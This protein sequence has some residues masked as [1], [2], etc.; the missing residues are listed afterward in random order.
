MKKDK[1]IP[2]LPPSEV[3]I[4]LNPPDL[5]QPPK[6]AGG[7]SAI[8][9]TLRHT[10]HEMKTGDVIRS[11]LKVNKPDGF[12]CPGCAWPDPDDRRS[13]VEFCENGA[14]AIAE[15]ATRTRLELGYFKQNSI[16]AI[17]KLS[18]FELGHLGRL[19]HPM[20]KRQGSD[21]YESVSW[22]SAFDFIAQ[23]LNSL[24]SPNEATFY[25]SGRTSNEAAFL[26]Q[27]FV[28]M[29]GTNNLPDCSNM[30]HE[31]SGTALNE[32]IGIGKGTVTLED[33]NYADLILV[34]GQNPGTNHPRMMSALQAA[35]RR[36]CKIV[37]INPL[38]EVGLLAFKNPQEIQGIIGRG[39]PLASI[40]L[41]VRINGDAA[42][43][44]GIAKALIDLEESDPGTVLDQEFIKQKTSGFNTYI[45]HVKSISWELITNE[46]GIHLDQIRAVAKLIGNSKRMITCWAMGLTQHEN[47]VATIKE[48]VNVMLLGGHIG[49]KG[50]GVCP[51]RG[52]SN[53]QGDRTM[54]I[55]EK[56]PE[57]FLSRL[58]NEFS[59][60][61]PRADGLDT[62]DSIKAMHAG[63]V[64]V[65]IGLGGNFLS[66]TP[67]TFYTAEAL[68][69]C[70]LTVQISTKLNRSHLITGSQ[71]I[72]LPCL[73]R[74]EI[75]LQNSGPQFV[76]CE[77]SM[78][79]VQASQGHL[80]PA[81]DHL[82]SEVSIVVGLAQATLP[83]K[84]VNQIDKQNTAHEVGQRKSQ[85]DWLAFESN[86]NLIRDRIAKVI[87]G[88]ENYNSDILKPYGFYLPNGA[89]TQDF[90]TPSQKA[91]F[92][93]SNIKST[94]L[95]AGRYLLM[96]IRSHDQ[97]NTTIYGLNDR[98]RGIENGRRVV[99]MNSE[100][101]LDAGLNKGA[102]VDV[103]SHYLPNNLPHD[104]SHLEE[105]TR[106]AFKFTVVPYD[107]PRKC[108]A[109]YFPETNV[110]VPI[111]RVADK[112]NTP[113]YKSIEVS[114]RVS[115]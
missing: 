70:R 50:A 61:A 47:A 86:Y 15:E 67:D 101:M 109:A 54:G 46:C 74:S 95:A 76:S 37:S 82:K 77:N 21:H 85:M 68:K 111:H 51:V 107:I 4:E 81:S 65:F 92:T 5:R 29:Y 11:L 35:V 105:E 33:F 45:D 58:S 3:P 115:T 16:S 24:A 72:I 27:L 69:K 49:R 71:A 73:G 78:G 48:L 84:D 39:T 94:Q 79:V 41:Q 52:H 31:S 108:L 19:T 102:Q 62:V 36:G 83:R 38:K 10:L 17:S 57:W 8:T 13:M 103:I 59:F 44:L 18:D 55:Y 110:L 28:R 113:A 6:S 98:Y 34:A 91:V 30:C 20:I 9:S 112:S 90:N 99:F 96:T 25:T 63:R 32:V 12:D 43:F 97:F 40:F 56:M 64:K 42:L 114:I 22:Q 66:A 100:D 23:E 60:Q 75:D 2:D 7:V 106:T 1:P 89:R 53:V 14:K 104:L 88:F 87:P 80:K 93:N 26:Y